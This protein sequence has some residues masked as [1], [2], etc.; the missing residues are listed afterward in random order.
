MVWVYLKEDML[1]YINYE[2]NGNYYYRLRNFEIV[3]KEQTM[4]IF[5]STKEFSV[6]G[7]TDLSL[8]LLLLYIFL[9]KTKNQFKAHIFNNKILTKTIQA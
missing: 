4:K 3:V 2:S 7:L 8:Q 1:T 9:V 5:D 6:V